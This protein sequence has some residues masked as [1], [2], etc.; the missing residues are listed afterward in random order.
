MVCRASD[1]R[2]YA[3]A[4]GDAGEDSASLPDS[5]MEQSGDSE[6]GG[7]DSAGGTD[8]DGAEDTNAT[9]S[10]SATDEVDDACPEDDKKTEPGICGCG[11]PDL[12]S[13]GDGSL[14]CHDGC[15]NDPSRTEADGCGCNMTC[16]EHCIA[17]EEKD[18][19][20]IECK[21]G[22]ILSI[23][24]ALFG[25]LKNYCELTSPPTTDCQTDSPLAD[26]QQSC[27][28]ETTCTVKADKGL[29]GE[30]CNR[31]RHYLAVDYVCQVAN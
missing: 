19:Y 29:Y 21:G 28:G 27:E 22:I 2:C 14:D 4:G 3:V 6:D 8:S 13:D 5:D 10:E 9:D 26:L 7:M 20:K 30:Q 12:D 24:N 11:V 17:I 18:S 16:A 31:T 23:E 25:D 15:P 1:L